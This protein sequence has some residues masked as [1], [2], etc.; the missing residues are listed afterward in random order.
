MYPHASAL[1]P[2]ALGTRQMA[3]VS[4]LRSAW[5]RHW[6]H[7]VAEAAGIAFFLSSASLLT[8]LLEHP[9]SPGYQALSQHPTFR[10][11]LMAVAMALVIVLIV[12]SPWGKRSGAHINPA[13]TVAFWHLG[14]IRTADAAWYIVAQ[15]AGAIGAGQLMKLVLGSF[16]AHPAVHY[17]T[18]QPKP[19]GSGQAF[20]G[21]FIISFILMMSMLVAL[22]SRQ[23]KKWTGWLVG[24][25]LALFILF[26]TPFSGMSLNPARTLGAAVAA[27]S[28][29]GL[30]IYWAAP[31]LAM[32]LATSTF[33]MVYGRTSLACAVLA[34]CEAAANT[35]L[36]A[37]AGPATAEPPHYPDASGK[38]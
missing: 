31:V 12:Y 33:Q 6:Q 4:K 21:E 32:W 34:G 16:Y 20:L 13:V 2:E 11:A 38:G 30:W 36:Y 18:T 29:T 25:L 7:Y 24:L 15:V 14:K 8:V 10:T 19:G 22:H 37:D 9:A 5:Q 27:N 35:P 28:Y 17:V 26:E 1:S 23:L 3:F